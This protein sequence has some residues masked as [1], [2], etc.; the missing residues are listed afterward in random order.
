MSPIYDA[1]EKALMASSVNGA[2]FMEPEN[3]DI[4]MDVLEPEDKPTYR[5][6]GAPSVS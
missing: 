2:F 3:R 5:M 1:V 4:Y 6:E